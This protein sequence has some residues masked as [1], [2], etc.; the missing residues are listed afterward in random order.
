[1]LLNAWDA[2]GA[3]EM[4]AA[5]A[6]AIATTSGGVALAHGYA[7]GEQT[8]PQVMFDAI[9][10]IAAAVDVPVT[11]DVESGYGLAADALVERVL[12]AGAVGMNLE[13]TD[14]AGGQGLVAAELQAE[15]LA[16]VKQS[17]RSAGVEIVLNARVDVFVR[18]LGTPEEQLEEAVRRTRLYTEAGA[19]CVYPIIL[20]EEAAIERLVGEARALNIY[21]RPGAPPP[22]RLAELGVARISVGTALHRAAGRWL[23]RAAKALL[24]GDP[25]PLAVD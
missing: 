1:M 14:H 16:N 5:G 18:R 11:A 21:L 8:P 2:S 17:A 7:D 20:A 24:E 13:D 23:S 25:S 9:G 15:R 10:Q 12:A 3:R 19:D 6:A 4:A 22:S